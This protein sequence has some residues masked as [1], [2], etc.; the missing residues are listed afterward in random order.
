MCTRNYT[1]VQTPHKH[2]HNTYKHSL[3]HRYSTLELTPNSATRDA[4]L[5]AKWPGVAG[6]AEVAGVAGV[7]GVGGML[8]VEGEYPDQHPRVT[9]K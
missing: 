8:V 4:R 2:T 1:A 5:R 6:M 7:A 3:D 9:H